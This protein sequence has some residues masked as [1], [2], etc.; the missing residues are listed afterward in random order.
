MF[1]WAYSFVVVVIVLVIFWPC[2]LA[3]GISALSWGLNPCISSMESYPLDHQAILLCFL[4][5][6]STQ[7]FN[8][9]LP[10]GIC[11]ESA[12][13]VQ[14]SLHPHPAGCWVCRPLSWLVCLPWEAP[15][16]LI[17]IWHF[18]SGGSQAPAPLSAHSRR[19]R[20]SWERSGSSLAGLWLLQLGS[21]AGEAGWGVEMSFTSW[22]VTP[23]SRG[24]GPEAPHF[25]WGERTRNKV[26][27]YTISLHKIPLE[28]YTNSFRKI[29]SLINFKESN[30]YAR[31]GD[32]GRVY[33]TGCAAQQV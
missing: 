6:S 21:C 5:N 14:T 7:S 8:N 12:Q 22:L 31:G 3:C 2:F 20:F 19:V 15:Q 9:Q 26:A 1:S 11:P 13:P 24:G 25:S 30:K 29:T 10:D 17:I 33:R 32:E 4:L 16:L 27:N 23:I 28:T 18:S